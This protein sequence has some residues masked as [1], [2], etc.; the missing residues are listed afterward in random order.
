MIIDYTPRFTCFD[1]NEIKGFLYFILLKEMKFTTDNDITKYLIFIGH[2]ITQLV[3]IIQTTIVYQSS[4]VNV[5]ILLLFFML[6]ETYCCL[7]PIS[8]WW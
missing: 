8:C 1:K 6:D 4:Y 3:M 5:Y 7:C 2:I